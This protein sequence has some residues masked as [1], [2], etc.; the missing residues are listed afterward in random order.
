VKFPSN[1]NNNKVKTRT[2]NTVIL[3]PSPVL[4]PIKL[5]VYLKEKSIIERLIAKAKV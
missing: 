4:F 2:R 1:L 5:F 3:T